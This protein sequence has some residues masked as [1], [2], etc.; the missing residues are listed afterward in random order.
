[1]HKAD[2]L[3]TNT[4]EQAIKQIGQLLR[5]KG[6]KR[7]INSRQSA[8]MF[9]K[10]QR[11]N[12]EIEFCYHH[13]NGVYGNTKA[14]LDFVDDEGRKFGWSSDWLNKQARNRFDAEYT[15]EGAQL[16]NQMVTDIL[17][18]VTAI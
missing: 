5:Q 15:E 16:H 18:Y 7:I 12:R 11:G 3:V 4:A 17:N 2:Q 13:G 14:I 8:M 10:Y 1:M 6:F 9:A